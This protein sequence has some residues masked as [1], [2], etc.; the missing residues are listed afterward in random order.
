MTFMWH[1]EQ[2]TS[3]SYMMESSEWRQSVTFTGRR[4][5]SMQISIQVLFQV[6]IVPPLGILYLNQEQNYYKSKNTIWYSLLNTVFQNA[7][8]LLFLSQC[9]VLLM[10]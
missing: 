7:T 8:M 3:R 9:N 10:L 5:T 4:S 1:I 2:S 6:V